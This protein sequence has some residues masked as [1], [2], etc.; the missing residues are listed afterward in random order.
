MARAN[1]D[2]SSLRFSRRE[3]ERLIAALLLS[4]VAHLGVW[5]GYEA[6]KKTGLWEKV[7]PPKWLQPAAKKFPLQ[8][9]IAQASEPTIFVDVSHAD[10]DAPKQAKF[11]SN[12]NSRA[13]NPDIGN[14][15]VAQINGKQKDV[16]KTEDVPKVVSKPKAAPK[17]DDTP[18]LA[19]LQPSLPPPQLTPA[20]TPEPPQTPGDLDKLRPKKNSPDKT[21]TPTPTPEPPARAPDLAP[22][23]RAARPVARPADAA[24]G[25]SGPAG[26][27]VVARCQGHAVWRL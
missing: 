9:Q 23:A 13:A 10:A 5:A 12:K 25:R 2:T 20:E 8:A 27:V 6:G 24:A 22:G 7:H 3:S 1:K 26:A 16:P 15:S 17:A 11:Y 14:A 21:P 4:L 18:Q 19:K